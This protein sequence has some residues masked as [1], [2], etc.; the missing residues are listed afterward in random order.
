V[1][2]LEDTATELHRRNEKFDKIFQSYLEQR[3]R[4]KELIEVFDDDMALLHQ[5]LLFSGLH[6]HKMCITGFQMTRHALAVLLGAFLGALKCVFWCVSLP[7][8]YT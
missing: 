4:H 3:E 8:E 6:C 5:V 1:A 7:V 2:N